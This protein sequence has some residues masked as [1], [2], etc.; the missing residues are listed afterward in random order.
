MSGGQDR[1]G[2][3]IGSVVVIMPETL[4]IRPWGV[5]SPVPGASFTALLFAVVIVACLYIGREVL[6]PV[7][8]A[9]L[10]SFVL[11]PL[12]DLLQRWYVP[13]SL[14]VIVVVL[15]AFAG[16]FSLGVLMVS[17]VNQLAGDLPRY[18]ST[19]REKIQSLRGSATGTGTLQRASEVLQNLSQEI[20]RSDAAVPPVA[21]SS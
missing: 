2:N 5:S 17:Q 11:A 4:P 3:T 14:S 13:R 21:A 6:V 7:A 10:M 16:V 15:L 9:V 1:L 19:L 18:Q 20:N 12:V 8:L